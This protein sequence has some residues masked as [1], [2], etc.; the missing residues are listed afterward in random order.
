[1]SCEITTTRL[2]ARQQGRD[3]RSPGC[4]GVHL[5]RRIALAGNERRC[6]ETEDGEN[7]DLVEHRCKNVTDWKSDRT[8]SYEQE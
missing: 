4:S 2:L 6:P 8:R 3:S 7:G 5:T 1:M